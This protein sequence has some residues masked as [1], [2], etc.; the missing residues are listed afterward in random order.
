M[1]GRFCIQTWSVA[2]RPTAVN[3]KLWTVFLGHV[4]PMVRFPI[5]RLGWKHRA[6]F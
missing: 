4:V 6:A 2:G 1:L 5:D 3:T